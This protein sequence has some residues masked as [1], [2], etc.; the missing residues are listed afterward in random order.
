MS[1]EFSISDS[2]L[3]A[4]R[5]VLTEERRRMAQQV[6]E[7]D[8]T[9]RELLEVFVQEVPDD[10][11]DPDGTTAFERAQ[12]RSLAK[13]ARDRLA[14]LETSLALIDQVGFG[15]CGSCGKPIGIDRLMVR[16]ESVRCVTCAAS[17]SVPRLGRRK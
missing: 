6:A 10:E 13:A 16:P 5:K 15:R 4:L 2:D 12:I 9:Y 1:D 3:L 8:R 11:H 7:L 17:G 14:D